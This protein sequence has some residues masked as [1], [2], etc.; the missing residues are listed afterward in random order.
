M[1]LYWP[2]YLKI[3]EDVINLTDSVLFDD[4]QWEVYSIVIGDL[5]V[6]CSI[7]VESISKEL[8]LR[9]GGDEKPKDERGCVRD[10]Y[11][12]TDC[13][14]L[15]V[16][17]WNV[18]NKKLQIT[19]PKMF[20]SSDKRVLTPLYKAHRRG[21]SGSKWKRA[22]QAVKHYR[23]KE[24]YKATIGNLLNA[25]GA[26][27]ILNLYYADEEFWVETPI[28]GR[29][30]YLT[31]S[32]IFTPFI[33]DASKISMSPQMGDDTMEQIV[34]P[35]PVESVYVLKYTDDAYRGIHADFCI[36]ETNILYYI[37][38]SKKFA[39]LVKTQPDLINQTIVSQCKE[40]GF[41]YYELLIKEMRGRGIVH[42]FNEKEVVLMKQ[43]SIYP[44]L[45][46][47][48]FIN[49]EEGKKYLEELEKSDR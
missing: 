42:R 41:D 24:I 6:R 30:A 33:C 18:D 4:K 16:N 48:D 23:T 34:D 17:K 10:L 38:H 22:Y 7:E 5:L 32:N 11:F 35:T 19:S 20:F 45:T 2:V 13:I 8:Y 37:H 15:L 36:I 25:L 44:T 40:I 29:R 9:L 39:E 27:Y 12:D 14:G 43:S 46:Y 21:S 28:N 1:N 26:L 49:S 3:E 47:Y 31:E